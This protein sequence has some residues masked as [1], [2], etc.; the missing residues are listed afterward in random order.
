MNEMKWWHWYTWLSLYLEEE[1][2]IIPSE[3]AY[4]HLEIKKNLLS[5]FYTLACKNST[6]YTQS[7]TIARLTASFIGQ[8]SDAPC[9]GKET[10]H[11]GESVISLQYDTIAWLLMKNIPILWTRKIATLSPN[12]NECNDAHWWSYIFRFCIIQTVKC[13]IQGKILHSTFFVAPTQPKQHV[14]IRD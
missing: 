8:K 14:W 3:A 9:K 7:T 4:V 13:K 10:H 12:N 2:E 6:N 11:R 1:E 5:S